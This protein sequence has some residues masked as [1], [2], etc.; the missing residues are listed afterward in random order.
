MQ[1]KIA[2]PVLLI[3][4][5]A[6]VALPVLAQEK[7]PIEMKA[8]VTLKATIMA[9][10]HDTRII[11]LKDDKGNYE[12]VYAGPEV[13]RFNEL[14]VG[15]KVTF[16]YQESVV[17]QVRKPGEPGMPSGEQPPAIARNA[18]AKPS[19]SITE[20]QTANVTVQSV[21]E[22]AGAITVMTEDGR[23]MSYKVKDKGNLKGV[24]AGDKISITYTTA[25]MISV[26]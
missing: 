13:Q 12:D 18:T 24:V 16:K 19:G 26:Q 25:L 11:S 22:K 10:D 3:L 5:S 2:L 21:D 17:V 15:D 6:L 8:G 7:K 4:L 23:S 14:K 1:R 9:I 20:Q